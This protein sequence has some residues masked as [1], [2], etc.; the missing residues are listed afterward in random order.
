MGVGSQ[1]I[2]SSTTSKV[3]TSRKMNNANI[4]GVGMT[5]GSDVTDT[6]SR[7]QQMHGDTERHMNNATVNVHNS[8]REGRFTSSQEGL[9]DAHPFNNTAA[10]KSKPEELILRSPNSDSNPIRP[11][12][13]D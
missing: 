1:I 5:T 10:T 6:I 11:P 3:P 12:L 2:Q 13:H 7:L 8:H 9:H 4:L